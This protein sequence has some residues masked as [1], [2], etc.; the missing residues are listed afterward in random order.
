M[1]YVPVTYS[2]CQVLLR[3]WRF[4]T[5]QNASLGLKFQWVIKNKSIIQ[6]QVCWSFHESDQQNKGTENVGETG[7][8]YFR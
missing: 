8:P 7:G 1:F 5:E 3:H 4:F 6:R 2:L